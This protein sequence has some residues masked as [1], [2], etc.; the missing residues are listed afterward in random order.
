MWAL[1][2]P[3]PCFHHRLPQ[4]KYNIILERN[5]QEL[6]VNIVVI[7]RI[8]GK[9]L[10]LKINWQGGLESFQFALWMQLLIARIINIKLIFIKVSGASQINHLHWQPFII[11]ETLVGNL[12]QWIHLR[13]SHLKQNRHY[14]WRW[15]ANFYLPPSSM[16]QP[17][18]CYHHIAKPILMGLQTSF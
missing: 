3:T 12:V 1:T 4:H 14:F 9:D 13:L 15:A 17:S 16:A 7:K 5:I 18:L 8:K 10:W 6:L 2:R 11:H